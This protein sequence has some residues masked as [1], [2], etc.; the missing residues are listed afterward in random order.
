MDIN[1]LN[2]FLLAFTSLFTMIDPF[3]VMPVYLTMTAGLDKNVATKIAF[4]AC[5]SAFIILVIFSFSGSAIFNFFHISTHGLKI[6]GGILFFIMGYDMLQAKI[7]RV[8]ETHEDIEEFATDIAIT[9]LGI[10]MISGPGSITVVILMMKDLNGTVEVSA[11][12]FAI[13]SV[14]L[15]T[16]ILLL[17]AQKIISFI[18]RSGTNVMMRIMGLIIMTIAVEF[19][20]SGLSF[21]V[22][23]M[24]N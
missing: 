16:F 12:I 22:K 15:I 5:L 14:L 10:P 19:F 2:I 18:G 1:L 24:L 13:F 7:A 4:K 3:G 23:G 6:V 9:P 20:F 8:K 17:S 11:L 21:Y